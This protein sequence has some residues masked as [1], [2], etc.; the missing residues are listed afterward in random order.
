MY[1]KLLHNELIKID[2]FN[3]S[4]L[5]RLSSIESDISIEVMK[6]LLESACLSQN[7][8]PIMIARNIL[9]N[10]D[11]LWLEKNILPVAKTIINMD[12]E[13]EYRRFYELIDLVAPG[14]VEDVIDL[15]VK[16]NN[17][18]VVE[19]AFDFAKKATV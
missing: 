15:G 13:W 17:K 4:Q 3:C 5:Y 12:D 14:I 9:K 10:N 6:V 16:S 2:G 11:T 7:E 1:K 18:D 19:A 8:V